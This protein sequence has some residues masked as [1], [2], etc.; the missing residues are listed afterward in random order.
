MSIEKF[1]KKMANTSSLPLGGD[2]R[3]ELH[4]LKPFSDGHS[5]QT[6]IL[7][8]KG[9]PIRPTT[10]TEIASARSLFKNY[11]ESLIRTYIK[12]NN[13]HSELHLLLN[14]GEEPRWIASTS[15]APP[16]PLAE[17]GF[18]RLVYNLRSIWDKFIFEVNL[19]NMLINKAA[20]SNLSA[21]RCDQY[22]IEMFNRTCEVIDR[23]DCFQNPF[24]T[25][26]RTLF[27]YIDNIFS[28]SEML[29][30]FPEYQ[31]YVPV[32][33]EMDIR[34]MA[35]FIARYLI[36]YVSLSKTGMLTFGERMEDKAA[37]IE[38]TPA[39]LAL[40]MGVLTKSRVINDK[41]G[42]LLGPSGTPF[43]VAP[44]LVKPLQSPSSDQL[45]LF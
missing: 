24:R 13:C 36:D 31:S 5:R 14:G 10:P 45:M 42:Y 12:F 30:E 40:V 6:R 39:A 26:V 18:E 16:V 1:V 37:T 29:E 43:S 32:L 35:V 3:V 38:L 41:F 25:L 23:G 11:D 27:G 7:V 33:K 4:H 15:T 28:I 19:P 9:Y 2:V 21:L 17:L 20:I 34:K 44:L 22:D 8:E